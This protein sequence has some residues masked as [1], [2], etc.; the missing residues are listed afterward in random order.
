MTPYVIVMKPFEK[1]N[2]EINLQY[3]YLCIQNV[4]LTYFLLGIQRFR[5]FHTV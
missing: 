2:R 5:N 4:Y 3:S 1:K